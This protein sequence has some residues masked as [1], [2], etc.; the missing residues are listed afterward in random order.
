MRVAVTTP[1]AEGTLADLSI[2]VA[3]SSTAVWRTVAELSGVPTATVHGRVTGTTDRALVFGRDAQG[4]AQVRARVGEGGAFELD[5]PTTVVEWY[6]AIDP[7]RSSGLV[8]FV[9]GTPRDLLLDVSPGGDLHVTIVNFDGPSSATISCSRRERS[10][11]AG[12]TARSTRA[13]APTSAP[14]APAP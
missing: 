2:V 6:A 9:P 3:P 13:S 14:R 8:P 10:W 4:N 11:S 7:G 5:V 1:I 12:S